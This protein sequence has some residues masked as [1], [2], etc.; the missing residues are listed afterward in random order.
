MDGPTAR[1]GHTGVVF[2]GRV[3]LGKGIDVS[4]SHGSMR[5]E[6]F[7]THSLISGARVAYEQRRR[8]NLLKQ[9]KSSWFQALSTSS[10]K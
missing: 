8:W 5:L 7:E 10:K 3:V 2:P 6:N 1:P 9:Q 4:G